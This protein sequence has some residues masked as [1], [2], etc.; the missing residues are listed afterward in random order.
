V[1]TLTTAPNPPAS[2]TSADAVPDSG[3][4]G[5]RAPSLNQMNA[6]DRSRFGLHPTCTGQSGCPRRKALPARSRTVGTTGKYRAGT[7]GRLSRVYPVPCACTRFPYSLTDLKRAQNAVAQTFGGLTSGNLVSY[8]EGLQV[9]TGEVGRINDQQ[10][11]LWRLTSSFLQ[12]TRLP[13]PGRRTAISSG[14]HEGIAVRAATRTNLIGSAG[15][16]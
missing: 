3:H 7:G 16:C 12:L 11:R 15:R 9:A 13:R 14:G 6:L 8:G 5:R 4:A 2:P 1:Q 10:Q